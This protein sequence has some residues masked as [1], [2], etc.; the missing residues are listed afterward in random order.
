MIRNPGRRA[1]VGLALAATLGLPPPAMP[2]ELRGDA[3]TL[4]EATAARMLPAKPPYSPHAGRS[5][6]TR[7]LFGDTHLHTAMS[8][9][10]GMLGARLGAVDANWLVAVWKDPDFDPKQ[11]AFYYGRVIEIPTPRWTA[12][13]ARRFGI[14]MPADVPMTIQERAYTSPI[15]YTP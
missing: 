13:D 6:P 10:A 9:D 12:Y 8:F 3:G 15:W 4:D 2:T 14:T 1:I 5:F 7:P 11:R